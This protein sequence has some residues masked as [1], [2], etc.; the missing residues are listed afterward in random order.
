MLYDQE[1]QA[2]DKFRVFKE[3]ARSVKVP[4]I[5][6]IESFFDLKSRKEYLLLNFLR[7]LR[8][9]QKTFRMLPPH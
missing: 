9:L 8:C 3:W 1:K 5:S 7:D 6:A 2:I 4:T